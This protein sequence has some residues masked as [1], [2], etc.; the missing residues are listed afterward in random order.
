[1][2]WP[3]VIELARKLANK[4]GEEYIERLKFEIKEIEKQGANEYWTD[5][6]KEKKKFDDNKNGLV[7]P[8]LLK[9]TPIDPI[10]ENIEHNISYQPDFPDIDS[11][12]LPY[13]RDEIKRYI[14]EAYGAECVCTVG[15]W[16]TLK[17]KQALQDAARILGEDINQVIAITRGMGDEYDEM[18]DV[19]EM[20]QANQDLADYYVM[21]PEVVDLAWRLKGKIKSQGQHAGG[22]IISSVHLNEIIPMSYINGKFVSQWTE[23]MSASQLSKFGLVK[24]DIL[25]LRTMAY[26][27]YT[28]ELIEKVRGV[29]IDWDEYDPSCEEPYAGY[30]IH[31]DGTKHKILLNDPVAI[32]MADD[33]RTEAVFQFDTPVAKGVLSNGVRTFNDL[34]AYTALARPGPMDM[35]PEYVKRRDDP[36]QLWKKKEDPR[37]IELLEKTFGII[38][39]QEQLTKFWMKFG[40]LTAPEAEK[41]RKAVAK[42]KKE[43]VLKLGPKI[44]GGMIKNGFSEKVAKEWWDKMVTF[45]RYCFNLSHAMAYGIIAYRSLWLKAHYP[46]E[47]WAS[48]LTYCHPDRIPRY[49]SVAKT[50]DV[51]FKPIRCGNLFDKFTVDKDLNIHSSLA[52]IKGVGESVAEALSQGG[53]AC[54]DIDDF[55]E[56]YG[57]KK[58]VVERL[59]K[60]GAFDD[61]HSHKKALWHWYIYKYASGGDETKEVRTRA[62]AYFL[63]KLWPS[64]KIQVERDRQTKAYKELYPNRRKIP[65]KILNWKPKIGHRAD[66][67]TREQFFEY[68]EEIDDYTLNECLEF[69]MAYLGT[70]WSDPLSIYDRDYENTFQVC[71]EEEIG[72][73]DGVVEKWSD[74]TTRNGHKYRNYTIYDGTESWPVKIWNDNIK[75]QDEVVF[76][77]GIGV[78]ISAQ[79]SEKFR[80]YNLVRGTSITLLR[81]IKDE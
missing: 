20:C 34:V 17:I 46:A 9:I 27:V 32:D 35:I 30:E 22:I 77:T 52:M 71:R 31:S 72:F 60:L 36:K 21:F 33:V 26:N 56:K 58:G 24:F 66:V 42:K 8:Y 3:D 49:T 45:G 4:A 15:N 13:A 50:E 38:V 59:V 6:I 51:R 10:K 43:E 65:A 39:Y 12:F 19:E 70:Y 28:E 1:M 16:N 41:A 63:E 75:Y 74:G 68:Y 61:I 55:V 2:E 64:D 40:G 48:I 80:G 47:F 79:W 23:G 29:K 7:L 78:R 25:G 76:T 69:E 37:V 54:D 73:V 14:S 5:L 81:K 53:G 67:P 18:N 57:K 11:D 44:I 62:T